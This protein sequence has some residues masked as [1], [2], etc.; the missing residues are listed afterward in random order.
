MS[1]ISGVVIGLF[2]GLLARVISGKWLYLP[3]FIIAN[4]LYT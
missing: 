4:A 1:I 2:F 3:L